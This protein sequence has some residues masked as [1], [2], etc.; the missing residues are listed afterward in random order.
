M[1]MKPCTACK[2]EKPLTAF[3]K[4][5][6]SSGRRGIC[7]TCLR[8]RNRQAAPGE[9]A[10]ENMDEALQFPEIER[11]DE[12]VDE[13]EAA[14]RYANAE[15]DA[16]AKPARKR[17]RRRKKRHAVSKQTAAVQDGQAASVSPATTDADRDRA[18]D[19]STGAQTQTAPAVSAAEAVPAPATKRKRKR[20]H[21]RS[22]AAKIKSLKA[23]ISGVEQVAVRPPNRNIMPIK[24]AFTY[25]TSLLN[26]RGRGHI[27]LRGHRETGK[28]WSTDI[29]TEMAVRMV[30]EG[31]AGI[32][33]PGLIHKLYTKTDF[34]LLVLQRD[35]YICK[36][37]GRYGDTIDHV[38]PKSKGGLSSPANCVCACAACNL[39]KADKL[40]FVFDDF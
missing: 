9:A 29:P 10:F 35:D 4:R 1:D 12:H 3:T 31:A 5:A 36:Y 6:G 34:R 32:I 39:K 33:N 30:E 26:D 11:E 21:K 14:E 13:D 17:K 22:K 19:D 28:R 16:P 37:C 20:R 27:R 2:I 40:D 38:L 24:G 15:E 18:N 7:R 23:E 8:K 25:K